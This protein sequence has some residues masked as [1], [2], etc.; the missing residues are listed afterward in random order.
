MEQK[1]KYHL[2]LHPTDGETIEGIF[3]YE[4]KRLIIADNA[5]LFLWSKYGG[6]FEK[7][8]NLNDCLNKSFIHPVRLQISELIDEIEWERMEAYQCFAKGKAIHDE[9][10]TFSKRGIDFQKVDKVTAECIDKWLSNDNLI[11]DE[12]IFPEKVFFGGASIYGPINLID[13]I[14]EGLDHRIIFKGKSGSGKST[15]MRKFAKVAEKQKRSVQYFPCALDP[16]SIDMIIIPSL[17]LAVIDGTPPHVITPTREGDVS[18]DLYERCKKMDVVLHEEKLTE[19]NVKYKEVMK[20]GT[21]HLRNVDKKE[22]ILHD[23]FQHALRKEQF[24][25]MIDNVAYNK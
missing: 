16:R 13:E 25:Q 23:I 24:D 22:D 10:E 6:F 3:L 12:P 18:L 1:Q 19:I 14:T 15:F 5:P 4:Q 17:S 20:K 9:V 21:E 11:E 2:F 7:A 8:I